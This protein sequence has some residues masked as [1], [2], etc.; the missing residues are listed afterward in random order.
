MPLYQVRPVYVSGVRYE[1]GMEDGFIE[2]V[3]EEKGSIEKPY[4]DTPQGKQ[5]INEGDFIVTGDGGDFYRYS[6]KVFFEKFIL[7]EE[8]DQQ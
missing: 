7:V 6:P 4:I 1:K 2:V 5:T 8:I 3:D